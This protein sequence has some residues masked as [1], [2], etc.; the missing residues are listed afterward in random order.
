MATGVAI[1]ML[2]WLVSSFVENRTIKFI[3]ELS[4]DVLAVF[5]GIVI[6]A[7]QIN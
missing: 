4:F 6:A 2:G 5:V 7:H 3:I 1:V